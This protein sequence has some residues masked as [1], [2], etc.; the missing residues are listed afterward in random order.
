MPTSQ[1]VCASGSHEVRRPKPIPVKVREA[2][3]AMIYGRPDDDDAV[4]LDFI[5]AAKFVGIRANILRKWLHKPAVVALIRRERTAFRTAICAA[6]EYALKKVRDTSRNPMGVCAAV[7][8]LEQISDDP[9][10]R[11]VA[12]E[13][14]HITINIVPPPASLPS[15]AMKTIEHSPAE[16]EPAERRGPDGF[17]CDEFGRRV[18][19]PDRPRY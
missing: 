6:N 9:H 2:C 19:D 10:S 7:R 18:F 3:L 4:P 17:R 14:P 8:G 11:G 12:P 5:Q 16:L 1:P 13:S 15:P